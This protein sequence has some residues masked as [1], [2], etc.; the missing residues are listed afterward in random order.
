MFSC[1]CRCIP[2]IDK[3][4]AVFWDGH[5]KNAYIHSLLCFI[6]AHVGLMAWWAQAALL[7]LRILCVA[8]FNILWLRKSTRKEKES[9]LLPTNVQ[10]VQL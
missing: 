5:T 10:E 6:F 2:E 4:T 9:Q 1:F 8:D 7:L 3:F